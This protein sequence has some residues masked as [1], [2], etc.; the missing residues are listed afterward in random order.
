[1][2]SSLPIRSERRE[3]GSKL[4]ETL[5]TDLRQPERHAGAVAFVKHP[6]RQLTAK[7][8]PLIRVDARQIL[9]APE[10]RYLQGSPEQRVPRIRDRRKT[11]TVCR[12][13]LVVFGDRGRQTDDR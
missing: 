8:R 6:V 5:D 3:N 11:K 9:A 1:L 2:C 10:W 12:M 13:S 7:V 4:V